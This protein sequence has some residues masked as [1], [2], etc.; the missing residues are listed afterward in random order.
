MTS[1]RPLTRRLEPRGLSREEAADYCGISPSHFDNMRK[2]GTVPEPR[3]LG[4][5]LV[6]DRLE[7]DSAFDRIPHKGQP[8]DTNPWND[9]GAAA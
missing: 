7:L 9:R 6:Y 3:E 8:G 1:K 2:A 5:R 4:G